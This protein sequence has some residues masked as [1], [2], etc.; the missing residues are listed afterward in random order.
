MNVLPEV[1]SLEMQS[2]LCEKTRWDVHFN[3]ISEF[4]GHAFH[5]TVQQQGGTEAV[6]VVR[7]GL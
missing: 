3:E 4:Q 1:H 6:T 2:Q 7:L 5:S